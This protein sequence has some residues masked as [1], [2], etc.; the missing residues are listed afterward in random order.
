[1][2][3][4]HKEI[5]FHWR[6][7]QGGEPD[8][9]SRARQFELSSVTLPDIDRQVSFA[10]HAEKAGID[11]LLT[12]VSYG[13]PDPILLSSSII[14]HT[15]KIKFLVALRSGMT[16]PTFFV[17]QMNTFSALHQGRL[18]LNIV[19]G[20]SPDEM[21]YYGDHLD[22]DERYDRT[23]EFLAIC[24]AFWHEDEPVNFK[25]KYY[26]IIEGKIGT[27]YVS[28]ARRAP[29]IFIA[30]SSDN[31]KK[32][33][34]SQGDCW[35]RMPDLPE[36]IQKEGRSVLESGK[37]IG[38]R[39]SII[40]RD[41]KEEAVQAAYNLL[42]G[43]DVKNRESQK[44]N[45]FVKNS[46]SIMMKKMYE[47]SEDEWITPWLWTGAI[48]TF[49]GPTI[50]M[51]GTPEELSDAIMEYKAVGVSQFIFSGWPKLGEMKYFG[52][53]VLPLVR[54]KEAAANKMIAEV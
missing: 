51:V 6:L 29:Y 12:D 34:I 1:M 54:R 36:V 35:M 24:N 22:H 14:T 37:D 11:S 8:S 13:K 52:E 42:N 18:L 46:D 2:K 3:V 26:H 39:L 9:V 7:V 49:G 38:L 47:I 50:A 16:T 19:A 28:D 4:D 43:V 27:P 32:L 45:R 25:G 17:Q 10:R 40:C 30:G 31:A 21:A 23:E 44:E 53:K 20:H 15:D 48:R 41:S 33:A 5:K